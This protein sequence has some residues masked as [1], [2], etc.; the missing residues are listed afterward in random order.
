MFPHYFVVWLFDC[1][2]CFGV[3]VVVL[4]FVLICLVCVGLMVVFGLYDA[5]LFV[6]CDWFVLIVVLVGYL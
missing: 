2:D 6:V 3:C 5:E 1:Y 4:T